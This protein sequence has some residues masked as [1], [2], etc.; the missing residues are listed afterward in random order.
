LTEGQGC[1]DIWI[2][3]S[4]GSNKKRMTDGTGVNVSPFWSGQTLYFVSDRGGKENIWSLSAELHN[5]SAAPAVAENKAE[6]TES[7]EKIHGAL[8]GSTDMK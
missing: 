6:K 7:P 8:V 5:P 4:D 3:N 2:I 1:Q